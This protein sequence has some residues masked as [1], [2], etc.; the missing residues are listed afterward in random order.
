MIPKEVFY[1]FIFPWM[2]LIASIPGSVMS[3]LAAG[4]IAQLLAYLPSERDKTKNE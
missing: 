1:L 2:L 4:A 3:Y